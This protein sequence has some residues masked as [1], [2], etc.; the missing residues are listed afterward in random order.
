MKRL[1][2]LL[3]SAALVLPL[4]GCSEQMMNNMVEKGL[5]KVTSVDAS[6][7][8]IDHGDTSRFDKQLKGVELLKSIKLDPE[9]LKNDYELKSEMRV[10]VIGVIAKTDIYKRGNS[11]RKV[12]ESDDE[13][14]VRVYNAD[15]DKTYYWDV[16][17]KEGEIY[18]G[19]VGDFSAF[20]DFSIDLDHSAD[21]SDIGEQNFENL[22]DTLEAGGIK[23][24]IEIVNRYGGDVLKVGFSLNEDKE[25]TTSDDDEELPVNIA[26]YMSLNYAFPIEV[27]AEVKGA[28]IY[29]HIVTDFTVNPSLDEDLFR[30]PDNITFDE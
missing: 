12:V 8:H 27:S 11:Y 1:F 6:D 20:E 25:A 29:T 3:I 7:V 24:D 17:E 15:E 26:M 28:K 21:D 16:D 19:K 5:E 13:H 30:Q 2:V 9:Y 14:T 18:D 22:L 23:D 10:P 4:T